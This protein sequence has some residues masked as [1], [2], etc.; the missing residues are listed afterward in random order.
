MESV[1][2]YFIPVT[3]LKY[4]ENFYVACRRSM[5]NTTICASG[6]LYLTRRGLC[7]PYKY[8]DDIAVFCEQ[9]SVAST[10]FELLCNL[11]NINDFVERIFNFLYEY[12]WLEE[13]EKIIGCLK[14]VVGDAN[15]CESL[16]YFS[17]AMVNSTSRT[18]AD[19]GCDLMRVVCER[20]YSGMILDVYM[21]NCAVSANF[22]GC[23]FDKED[24]MVAARKYE[25]YRWS[26]NICHLTKASYLF[27][28]C[29]KTGG[30]DL[31]DFMRVVKEKLNTI[32]ERSFQD[33]STLFYIKT[34]KLLY[35]HGIVVEDI[36][37]TLSQTIST[38]LTN[39][40]INTI[41]ERKLYESLL[42]VSYFSY[43]TNCV[44]TIFFRTFSF[45]CNCTTI[46]KPSY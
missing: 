21:K 27:Y 25:D 22:V 41:S 46:N 23:D 10:G 30:C 20:R 14:R 11:S 36:L 15:F 13:R 24:L 9:E 40:N 17:L 29:A 26:R 28:N 34:L 5:S 12:R 32:D 4:K 31:N 43:A 16:F 42:S 2:S 44:I 38:L 39:T 8:T 7:S 18:L 1:K 6:L 3:V 37:G 33:G 19:F 35:E 45:V